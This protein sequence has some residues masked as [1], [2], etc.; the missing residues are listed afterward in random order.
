MERK[1]FIKQLVFRGGAA[2]LIPAAVLQAC[3]KDDTTD[4]GPDNP[5]N[6]N[7][8]FIIDLTDPDYAALQE[9]GGFVLVNS[10]NIIVIHT[11]TDEYTV[12]SS[13]CTHEGCRISYN[14]GNNTLPCPCHGSVFNINGGVVNGPANAP[15]TSYNATLDGNDLVID[16]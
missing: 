7:T 8:D 11:D 3:E 14:S 16:L 2:I 9:I 13:V 1:A 10:K 15:L 4:D 12:L 6:G 5:G